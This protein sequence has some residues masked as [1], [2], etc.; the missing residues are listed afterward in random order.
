[1]SER[2]ALVGWIKLSIMDKETEGTVPTPNLNA[3]PQWILT[4]A[5]LSHGIT[6]HWV[7]RVRH[8]PTH[9]PLLFQLANWG[10]P[11]VLHAIKACQI[12]KAFRNIALLSCSLSSHIFCCSAGHKNR[13][14][15]YLRHVIFLFHPSSQTLGP[16]REHERDNG[17]AP[18][19]QGPANNIPYRQGG[20][21]KPSVCG[22]R[23]ISTTASVLVPTHFWHTSS[24]YVLI[25]R[26]KESSQLTAMDR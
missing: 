13:L 2:R 3:F 12:L 20:P 15:P 6:L 22:P 4:G 16:S 21:L 5:N 8:G 1:M 11:K 26:R 25:F 23:N 9:T 14:T 7:R 24:L 10:E 19:V 18:E 17:R